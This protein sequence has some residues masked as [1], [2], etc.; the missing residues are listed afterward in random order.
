MKFL[1]YLKLALQTFRT[2]KLRSFLT[3]LGVIIGVLTV[4]TI[5]SLIQGLNRTVER[6]IQSLGSNS[7]YIQKVAWGTG[8][9]D[10][11]EVRKRKDLT[12]ED[13]QAISQLPSIARVSP[14]RSQNLPSI[15]YRGN[16]YKLA[17]I[18]GSNSELQYTGNYSVAIGRFIQDD[19]YRRARK[20]CCLGQEITENLFPY[21]DPL[22]K[23]LT[24]N[25]HKFT[26][27]GI[28]ARKGAFFGQTQD[29]VIIIPLTTY[30]RVFEKPTGFGAVFG[31]LSIIALPKSEKFLEKAIDEIR[32]LLRRRRRL[33]YDKPDDFGIN[34]QETLRTI[35]RNITN[36]AFLVMIAVA[37]ISLL[38]GGIGIMNIMLVAVVE[39]TREI[40]LRK[41]LGA[42]NREILL[43]FLT[44]SSTLSLIGGGIG[45]IG[46]I[47]LAKLIS[48]LTKLSAAAPIWTIILGFLFSV[49]IGIFFGIYPATRAA[50][51]NPISALRYE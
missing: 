24:I 8:R 44:E 39:R 28:L 45:V 17:E 46:G 7:I 9:I 16:K 37:A 33:G 34:T 43:Q 5:V 4:I 3:T 22:G 47:L 49:G 20:V 13:A 30:E 50:K 1:E 10:F 15:A 26:I 6:Q 21:E 48:L 42:T 12:L 36:V 19:D 35:Y 38:V 11:E 23:S 31:G 40:G 29:N 18:I 27:I 32:E 14:I 51:L 2:H 25:G 41:A